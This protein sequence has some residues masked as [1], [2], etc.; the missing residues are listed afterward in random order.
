MDSFVTRR[1]FVRTL[2][3]GAGA[4]A[5]AAAVQAQG[6]DSATAP[7]KIIAVSCSARAGKTTAQ[8]L[9]LGLEAAKAVDPE[10]IE[11]ELIE[12]A[13]LEIPAYV[14]AG[15]PL[16]QGQKDD[17]PD[18]ANRLADERVAGILIG[19]PVYFGSMTALCK[20]FLDRCISLRMRKFALANKVGGVV[21]VGGV[22][23]GGQELTIQCVQ[24]ALLCQE[25]VVVGDGRPTCHTGATV[26]NSG[27]DDISQDEFGVGTVKNLGRRVAEVAM[28]RA[29]A[30]K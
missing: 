17:F 14:A 4:M 21:A 28:S 10:Q 18:L 1:G 24:S 3:L 25:M 29:A 11:T 19:T 23:N 13:D 12:L 9:T 6:A 8:A 15:L 27:Q 20:A 2:G 30:V 26:W 5:G 16:K 22:R 7:I